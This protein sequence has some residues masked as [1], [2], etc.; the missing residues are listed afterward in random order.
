MAAAVEEWLLMMENVS[1]LDEQ[2][3][4]SIRDWRAEGVLTKGATSGLLGYLGSFSS[5]YPHGFVGY[6][7]EE[8]FETSIQRT[9]QTYLKRQAQQK[10]RMHETMILQFELIP[11]DDADASHMVIGD[12][13]LG[14]NQELVEMIKTN[15]ARSA[16]DNPMNV[17]VVKVAIYIV[18]Q[19]TEERRQKRATITPKVMLEVTA[20]VSMSSTC[21]QQC[22]NLTMQLMMQTSSTTTLTAL[23]MNQTSTITNVNT[24]IRAATM[25]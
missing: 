3:R 12:L 6:I 18:H 2:L 8:D 10:R 23:T 13:D 1:K 15:A 24:V 25:C 11:N 19:T 17:I 4:S 9:N 21:D 16:A 14:Q 7:S 5:E 22:I 20:M